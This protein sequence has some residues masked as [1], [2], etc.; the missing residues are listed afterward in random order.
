MLNVGRRDFFAM[1]SCS[2]KRKDETTLCVFRL[3]LSTSALFERVFSSVQPADIMENRQPD[4]WI[5]NW[6]FHFL[7][8]CLWH[9]V[10][11][12]ILRLFFLFFYLPVLPSHW[13]T[14]AARRQRLKADYFNEFLFNCFDA[15]FAGLNILLGGVKNEQLFRT[16]DV[17]FICAATASESVCELS[18][19]VAGISQ[20]QIMQQILPS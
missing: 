14:A 10:V 18:T 6:K 7:Y 20:W 3:H 11:I 8:L 13:F 17:L 12:D 5:Q 9:R 2:P 1:A 15:R 16:S 19:F 4:N